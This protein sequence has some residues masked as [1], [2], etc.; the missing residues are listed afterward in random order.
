MKS[1]KGKLDEKIPYPSFLADTFYRV[2][3]VAKHIFSSS[4]KVGLSVVGAPK[5]MI[6]DSRNIWGTQIKY[7]GR[8]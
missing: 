2:K 7:W 1:S 8:G 3:V 6:S 4:T 5:H